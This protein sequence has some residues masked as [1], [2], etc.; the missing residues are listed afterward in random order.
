LHLPFLTKVE[1]QKLYQDEA[2]ILFGLR[3]LK[4]KQHKYAAFD[5]L[6]DFVHEIKEETKDIDG[7]ATHNPNCIHTDRH[8]YKH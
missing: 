4:E 6:G 5:H 1:Y 7:D 8:I 3:K 2:G